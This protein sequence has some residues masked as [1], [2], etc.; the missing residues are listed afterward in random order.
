MKGIPQT[1]QKRKK[2]FQLKEKKLNNVEI[3]KK[4]YR[5]E[6]TERR[7]RVTTRKEDYLIRK[8][9]LENRLHTTTQTDQIVL[10]TKSIEVSPQTIRNRFHE[11]GYGG[12]LLKKKPKLTMKQMQMRKQFYETYGSWNA[13]KW[14]N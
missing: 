6:S 7:K 11:F 9:A 14:F 1:S 13:M 12:H 3:G 5:P 8:V 10:Q 4:M 2:I